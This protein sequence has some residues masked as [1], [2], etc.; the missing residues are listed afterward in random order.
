LIIC[1]WSN[2]KPFTNPLQEVK[3]KFPK[4]TE[5]DPCQS[6]PT[7][8][9]RGTGHVYLSSHRGDRAVC[10]RGISR[11]QRSIFRPGQGWHRAKPIRQRAPLISF[12]SCMLNVAPSHHIVCDCAP[13]LGRGRQ[14]RRCRTLHKDPKA[15]SFDYL[16]VMASIPDA[17]KATRAASCSFRHSGEAIGFLYLR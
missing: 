13:A 15:I 7:S 3:T 8:S 11:R 12:E 4:P 10:L 14:S 5:R 2:V 1:K 17:T 9:G 6:P 16:S